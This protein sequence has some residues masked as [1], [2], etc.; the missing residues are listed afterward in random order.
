MYDP[1]AT[2]QDAD[3]EMA[4]Y[5]REARAMEA[6]RARGVCQHQSSV[7]VPESGR[8]FYPEQ[9]GLVRPQVRCTEGCGTVFADD[10]EWVLAMQ[11]AAW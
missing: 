4:A 8:I 7:G 10:D 11:S 9:E 2:I 1:E 6:A 3:L 5:A